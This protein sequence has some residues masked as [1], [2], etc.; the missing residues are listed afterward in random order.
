MNSLTGEVARFVVVG[1]VSNIINFVTYVA[2]YY[3]GGLLVAASVAGYL[4]GTLNSYHFGKIWVF[5]A[6]KQAHRWAIVRF[7]AVYAVG[8]VLMSTVIAVLHDSLGMDYRLSW[9]FGAGIAFANNFIGSKV[10]V[11]PG[12]T[13]R[14]GK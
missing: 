7:L 11:F 13:P 10:L 9:V 4:A 5:P 12:S 8:G 14:D 1:V 6:G 2:V 3:F